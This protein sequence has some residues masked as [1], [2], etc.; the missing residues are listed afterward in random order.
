[1]GEVGIK[2]GAGIMVNIISENAEELQQKRV[3]VEYAKAPRI[4]VR[5]IHISN[6]KSIKNLDLDLMPGINVLVGKN[7]SGKSNILE[8]IYFM[9][10]AFVEAAE[11]VP[12]KPHIPNYWSPLDVIYGK[13]PNLPV[14]MGLVFDYYWPV[15]EKESWYRATIGFEAKLVYD[16][17]L[18]TLL[19]VQ[20]K[21]TI[22]N[23]AMYV[24]FEGIRVTVSKEFYEKVKQIFPIV[25]KE[26]KGEE[27][28]LERLNRLFKLLE[29]FKSE[30]NGFFSY[31]A[32]WRRQPPKV[33][34]LGAIDALLLGIIREI[35]LYN[36]AI[37]MEYIATPNIEDKLVA[38]RPI[39]IEEVEKP[40][41]APL[42]RYRYILLRSPPSFSRLPSIVVE[43]LRNFILLKHPDIGVL[44]EPVMFLGNDRLDVRARNLAEVLLVLSGRLGGFPERV[45][46]ALAELFPDFRLRVETRFGRA[47]LIG[48]IS[49]M[50]LPPSNL[51][52]GFIKLVVLMVAAELSP[53]MLLVDE[54]EN[55]MHARL[56]EYVVDEL[57]RL[58]IPVV[59]ATHSPVVVDLVS[60]ERI[61][62]VKRDL[63]KGTV[64]K[65]IEDPKKL[66]EEL[67]KEDISHSDHIFYG[68][69]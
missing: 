17:T 9:Y 35:N 32:R 54:L 68:R 50:E 41:G 18:D 1:M 60:P 5:R 10:K 59:V 62:I 58:E 26:M 15:H 67:R 33:L 13:D 25:M 16:R 4:L 49:G 27:E 47:V 51:P 31:I 57:N 8:A 22:N 56:L 66:S 40:R 55:S 12:Y 65:V 39:F 46:K 24:D 44:S 69:T 19:P 52:D 34:T 3:R 48:E 38:I 29:L 43:V 14:E 2:F 7:A 36:L 53:T 21:F 63:E 23:V 20:Y 11:K 42:S 28:M 64:V 61:L 37:A 45:S 30:K 6:F